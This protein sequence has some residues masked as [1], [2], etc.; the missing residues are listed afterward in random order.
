MLLYEVNLTV[1]GSEA[2]RFSS[3][4]REHI[5]TMLE[6]DGFEAAAWYLRSDDGET[7]PP[8]DEPAGPRTWTIHYQVRGREALQAYF[9]QHAEEMRGQAT[10]MFGDHVSAE[11]RI[12][13]QK[14]LF[15]AQR[16]EDTGPA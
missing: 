14:R 15:H 11:R 7:V 5:R 16:T 10:H 4:L 12:L 3:W 13:E 2:A 8:K 6:I 1:D 9:D